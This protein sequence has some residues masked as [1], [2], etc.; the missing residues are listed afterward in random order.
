MVDIKAFMADEVA[1]ANVSKIEAAFDEDKEASA[2][3]DAAKSLEDVYNL[4]KRYV[5]MKFED[6]SALFT[7]VMDYLKED[8]AVLADDTLECVVGGW[9]LG[10]LWQTVKKK[11]AAIVL[12]A[13]IGGVVGCLAGACLAGGVGAMVGGAVGVVVGAIVGGIAG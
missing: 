13:A 9:S 4:V 7:D 6:F 8:K 2:L 1:A 3:L 11:A 12:G 5:V 10:S